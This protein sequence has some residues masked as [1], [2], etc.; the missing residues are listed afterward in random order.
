ML[1]V[2]KST[3]ALVLACL[4]VTMG[5]TAATS[6]AADAV[7]YGAFM[8]DKHSVLVTVKFVLKI[9][10]GGRMGGMGDQESENEITAIAID[11]KG[12]VL[13][14]NTKLSGMMAMF[15]RM[16]GGE[17]SAIPTDI[18][19]LVGD[20]T[21]GIDA[22]LVARDTELDLAWIQVTDPGDKTF[23]F[24]DFSKSAEAAVGQR[25]LVVRKM[26]KYF[27]RTPVVVEGRIGGVTQKPRKLYVPTGELM[28]SLGLPV[29]LPN[30]TVIGIP[31][32]QTPDE[33]GADANPM[34]ML[35]RMSGMQEMMGGL[36][37]PA[38]EVVNATK[39]ALAS[40]ENDDDE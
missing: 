18:K 29:Y 21:E 27:G 32:T 24:L 10:M 7:D 40:V 2:S 36:I 33:E 19:V 8:K 26:D 1:P 16:M 31:I 14:S 22:E 20:D 15:G 13:C 3:R 38:A 12:L 39:R 37:L 4:A 9:K 34:A 23:E 35:G 6:R 17:M 30:G 11:S 25:V 28:S 5:L